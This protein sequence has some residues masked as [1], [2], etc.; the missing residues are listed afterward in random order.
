MA[1]DNDDARN[2]RIMDFA[3][4]KLA[5]LS[6]AGAIEDISYMG[7]GSNALKALNNAGILD[8]LVMEELG[9][10]DEAHVEMTVDGETWTITIR[11]MPDSGLCFHPFGGDGESM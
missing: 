7:V 9:D 11:Y 8:T 3:N 6:A 1:L 5:E 2:Q 10:G 4:K